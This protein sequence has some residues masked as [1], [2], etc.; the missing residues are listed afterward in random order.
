M[1]SNRLARRV[2][3]LKGARTIVAS[4]GA[5]IDCVIRD[6]S[7]SGARIQFPNPVPMEAAFELYLKA[8]NKRVPIRIAWQRGSDVG[9]EFGTKLTWISGRLAA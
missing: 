3:A 9:V 4:S 7:A 8:E 5:G 2:R 6:L 1:G